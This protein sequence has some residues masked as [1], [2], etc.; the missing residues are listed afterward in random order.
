MI[1]LTPRQIVEEL[2]RYIIGQKEAKRS[3]AIAV[4]NRWRRQQLSGELRNEVA[5]KNIIMIGP[6]GVG[7]T[8]I[9]RRL[10]HLV[11]APFLKVEAT[12]YTEVGYHG[13]DVESMIRDLVEISVNMVKQEQT[14]QVQD[15]A[16]LEAEEKL[17]DLLL[18]LP[19]IPHSSGGEAED[20][21]YEEEKKRRAKSRD[22]MRQ[23]LRAGELEKST[24]EINVEEKSNG[25]VMEIF[26]GG[27]PEQMGMDIQNIFE[28]M[29]P[30][31]SQLKK[32]S[33]EDARKILVQQQS[34]KLID[35]EKVSTEA[36]SRV[37]DTGIVFID[38][39]DKIAGGGAGKSPDVSRAG[40]QR[41][42]LPI[43]EGSTVVTR[44]GIVK[45]DHIL[46]IAAGAF[47]FSKPS[48]LI[49]ELQGRFPIR[50]EL[51]SLSQQD[52]LKILTEPRNALL[53]QYSAL[54]NTEN[55]N[56]HFTDDATVEI[57][58]ICEKVNKNTQ[59]I[60]AR[61]LHTIM[62]TL[63]EE[64]SFSAPDFKEKKV[65]IDKE[66]VCEKLNKIVQDEDL[67]RYIL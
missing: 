32:M 24:V 9:A 64:I 66:T 23:K 33:V 65:T 42:L 55:I 28:K 8:E 22:R 35:R 30:G 21:Q 34:E 17:L 56:I 5:P 60:G 50:V 18:P 20:I 49:P 26:T 3:V 44:Y 38:E 59:N 12:K 45:T 27:N 31:R 15:A 48:D 53:K 39:I 14:K 11:K 61:R 37:Q 13:R 67:S 10:A 2:D 57:A 1:N 6:T 36:L 4:R 47:S 29:V 43:V 7:K 41:D 16:S 25:P 19:P 54:L 51:Q 46:F 40:V 63:L 58:K 62:E 52:L